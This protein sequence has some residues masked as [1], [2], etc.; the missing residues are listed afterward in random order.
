VE[1]SNSP[2][3]IVK[4]SKLA[5]FGVV[6]SV[7]AAAILPVSAAVAAAGSWTAPVNVSTQAPGDNAEYPSVA[8]D[9]A[10]NTI[11]IWSFYNGVID[12]IQSSTS[13]DGGATWSAPVE[14]D[15]GG[16][17]DQMRI[18]FDASGNA[19]AMWTTR[20][21]GDWIVHSSS[22][23]DTGATW[24]TPE[25]VSDLGADSYHLGLTFDSLGNAIAVW[26]S[27]DGGPT[28]NLLASTSTNKGI[29]WSTPV[30]I[31]AGDSSTIATDANGNVIVTWNGELGVLASR[32]TDS[33]LTWSAPVPI[34]LVGQNTLGNGNVTIDG[35]GRAFAMYLFFDGSLNTILSVST[36]TDSGLTWSTPVEVSQAGESAFSPSLSIDAT[37]R[38][39]VIWEG[40]TGPAAG[41]IRSSTS[42]DGGI[43]WSD[44]I[45]VAETRGT[46]RLTHD[47]NSRALAIWFGYDPLTD[48]ST[49][50]S[51]T[52]IDGG[53]SW[54]T[55]VEFFVSVPGGGIDVALLTG[56][57]VAGR[58]IAL[59]NSYDDSFTYS[60]Q[61]ST[62]SDP[63]LPDT[64]ADLSSLGPVT[65]LGGGLLAAGVLALLLTRRRR[66]A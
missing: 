3:I 20:I 28:S 66:S 56:F 34:S 37:G 16:S 53:T 13:R 46:T 21:S 36:S 39:I 17:Y 63:S 12:A 59:W 35:S 52:S 30:V 6:V 27:S 18:S 29:T 7:L 45:A 32:S 11:A 61:S 54:S 25:T 58:A 1:L 64:G 38:A 50:Y 8:R 23:N 15:S 26:R 44:P 65:A 48:E 22:S 57:D 9:A 5:V 2:E 19:L 62:F 51:S 24:S 33:G 60:V 10:G 55:P 47:A 4:K 41:I 31:S 14:I 43:T 49:I 42:A 40:T